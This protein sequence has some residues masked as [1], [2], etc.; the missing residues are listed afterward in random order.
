MI[1]F[2]VLCCAYLRITQ[3]QNT[4]YNYVEKLVSKWCMCTNMCNWWFMVTVKQNVQMYEVSVLAVSYIILVLY[5][6]S[7]FYSPC[8]WFYCPDRMPTDSDTVESEFVKVR[9]V[10]LL[11]FVANCT[12]IPD[13]VWICCM[14]L[15]LK[16]LMKS[17]QYSTWKQKACS[18]LW[19][20]QN[21][22]S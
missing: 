10:M 4:L 2:A 20:L 8:G 19:L 5:L 15:R 22:L 1:D 3:A 18:L 13:T 21:S 9:L 7:K 17:W 16:F 11:V 6:K 14:S 12:P